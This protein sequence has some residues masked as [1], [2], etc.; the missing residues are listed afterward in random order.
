MCE[1]FLA[2][3]ISNPQIDPG[4]WDIVDGS[5]QGLLLGSKEKLLGPF[6]FFAKIGLENGWIFI[7]LYKNE[8][9][10]DVKS[11]IRL[12][13]LPFVYIYATC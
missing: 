1:R 4:Q 5:S 13:S 3:I 2:S 8:G 11:Y 12:L 7:I 9:F 6:R 10:V